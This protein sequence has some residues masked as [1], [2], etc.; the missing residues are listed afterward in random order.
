MEISISQK[1]KYGF[2]TEIL[3]DNFARIQLYM[4]KNMSFFVENYE[5]TNLNK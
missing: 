1:F 2:Q 4:Q 5:V 3:R